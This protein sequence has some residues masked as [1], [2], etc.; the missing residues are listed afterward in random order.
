MFDE[1]VERTLPKVSLVSAEGKF[2]ENSTNFKTGEIKTKTVIKNATSKIPIE[3]EK[4]YQVRK[5]KTAEENWTYFHKECPHLADRLSI[6]V[7]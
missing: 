3:T 4:N 6:D 1:R 7:D 5:A 2:G